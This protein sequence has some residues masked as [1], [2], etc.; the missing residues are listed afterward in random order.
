[1]RIESVMSVKK[2]RETCAA[3]RRLLL[4]AGNAAGPR[5]RGRQRPVQNNQR[6]IKKRKN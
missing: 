2:Q 6:E 5:P 4:E 1:M 3:L